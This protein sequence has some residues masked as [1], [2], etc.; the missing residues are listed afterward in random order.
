MLGQLVNAG[1]R[2]GGTLLSFY[3]EGARDNSHS[4]GAVFLGAFGNNGRSAGTGSAAHAGCHKH[5]VGIGQGLLYLCLAL[6]CSF[7]AHVGI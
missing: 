1:L 2:I 5:H 3:A 6:V 4:E 7:A